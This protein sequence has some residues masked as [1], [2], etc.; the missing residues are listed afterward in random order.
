MQFFSAAFEQCRAIA[1]IDELQQVQNAHIVV[2]GGDGTFHVAINQANLETNTFSLIPAGSGNDFVT[3]FPRNTAATLC[4]KIKANAIQQI[5]LVK[6]GDVYS[7]TVCGIGFEALVSQKANESKNPIP[8]LKFLF[9]VLRYMFV[10]KPINV[11]IE[12]ENY[13]YEDAAFMVSMG[14][15]KRAGGG[16]KLFPDAVNIDGKLDLLIIKKP[17]FW[18]KI[19]YVGLV[20]FGKH[21]H[22]KVVDYVQSSYVN[23]HFSGTQMLNADGDVYPAQSFEATV[24]PGKLKLIQ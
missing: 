7:H 22:L 21:Q 2:V 13:A 6:A 11:R 3:Q 1:S 8:A 9:P 12:A 15:G 23:F 19:L 24:L 10:F 16:F 20:N 4:A 18:Q 14:T 17:T 5:D